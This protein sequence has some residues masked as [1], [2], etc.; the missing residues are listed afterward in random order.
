[1]TVYV[2]DMMRTATV[3]RLRARWSH[4]LADTHEELIAM[5]RKIGLRPEW[6]QHEGTHREHFDLTEQRRTR[7]IALGAEQISYPRGTGQILNT[8]RERMTGEPDA[9]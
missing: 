7:A 6:I 4:M 8:K 2:D 9:P 5:A 3:G 1:M